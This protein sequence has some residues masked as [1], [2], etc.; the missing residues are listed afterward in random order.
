MNGYRFARIVQGDAD[1]E[2]SCSSR[3]PAYGRDRCV[4]I[5]TSGLSEFYIYRANGDRT[6][7]RGA[8]EVASSGAPEHRNESE[9]SLGSRS[10]SCRSLLESSS[11]C[12]FLG[13]FSPVLDTSL[14]SP[15]VLI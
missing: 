3:P 1:R 14:L 12:D 2:L 15:A 4:A 10:Q 5:R 6:L 8:P 9:P 7:R 13:Q 11:R